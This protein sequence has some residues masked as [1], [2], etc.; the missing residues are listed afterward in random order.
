[1]GVGLRRVAA[2]ERVW[3]VRLPQDT[4]DTSLREQ[5]TVETLRV[6]LR[7]PRL[8]LHNAAAVAAGDSAAATGFAC[9]CNSL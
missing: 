9:L 2:R 1:M 5:C 6:L 4:Q 3:G 7:A 8:Q